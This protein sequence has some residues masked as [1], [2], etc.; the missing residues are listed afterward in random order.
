MRQRQARLHDTHVVLA[1]F[2]GDAGR[3]NVRVGESE[4]FL[5][6]GKPEPPEQTPAACDEAPRGVLCKKVH[7]RQIIEQ[8]LKLLPPAHAREKLGL[9]PTT[10]RRGIGG[11]RA[12]G[13][14]MVEV[15]QFHGGLTGGCREP[16]GT[17]REH[18]KNFAKPFDAD[19]RRLRNAR[20]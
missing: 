18:K 4:Q 19:W 8:R 9:H 5:L 17:A 2:A 14:G 12:H 1:D 7:V 3:V 16:R 13:G 11:V 10:L 15:E 6:A 20:R